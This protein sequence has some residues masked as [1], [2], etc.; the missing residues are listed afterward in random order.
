MSGHAAHCGFLFLYELLTGTKS[1]KVL[2]DDVS[3]SAAALLFEMTSDKEVEGA[4]TSILSLM[5][6]FPRLVPLMPKF[7][8]DRKFK[9]NTIKAVGD[10]SNPTSPLG[11]LLG[12]CLAVIHNEIADI[13]VDVDESVAGPASPPQVCQLSRSPLPREQHGVSMAARVR[14]ESWVIPT[15]SDYSCGS[16]ELAEIPSLRDCDALLLGGS[17]IEAFSTLPLRQIGLDSYLRH[18]TRQQ[19]NCE[20][21]SGELPFDLGRHDHAQSAVARSMLERLRGDA[22]EYAKSQNSGTTPKLH[23]ILALEEHLQRAGA[24]ASRDSCVGHVR[25]CCDRLDQLYNDLVVLRSSDSAY[26]ES[27]V[28]WLLSRANDLSAS[29]PSPAAAKHV[30][31]MV[32]SMDVGTEC[33]RAVATVATASTADAVL[34]MSSLEGS[35]TAD[36]ADEAR[37]RSEVLFALKRLGGREASIWIEFLLASLLSSR[38]L[39]DLLRVN[40]FLSEATVTDLT[41]VMVAFILHASRVGLVNRCINDLVELRRGVHG[42]LSTG[43]DSLA[44]TVAGGS[45]LRSV[46]LCSDS[47]ARNLASGRHFV[48]N[49]PFHFSGGEEKRR[50]TALSYDPRFLV[51]EFTWNL[52]LRRS[53]VTMVR[54]YLGAVRAGESMVKQLIMGQGKTTVVCP[55]LTL[56]LGDGDNLVV[57]VVPPALLDF[58]R[59][60]M[61]S[62]F[63]TIMTKGVFTFSFD[64]SSEVHPSI[65]K[66]LASAK[67][68]RGV[69]ISTPT[70]VKS[71][72]LKYIELLTIVRDPAAMRPPAIEAD[73]AEL[74][75]NF[76]LLRGAVLI[77]DEVKRLHTPTRPSPD[78][79]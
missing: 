70:S 26:L 74:A 42:L 43:Q 46:L 16:R 56:I 76:R 22:L 25:G 68:A 62:T 66:K 44:A 78:L 12:A 5:C 60:I 9:T 67:T 1:L 29:P 20:P 54:D 47:L 33:E 23:C 51:F 4:M 49:V 7:K 39:E 41:N 69:V 18:V 63:S 48:D 75:K 28:P 72:M 52:M 30:A 57:L 37:S 35:A 55:L 34:S 71:L 38:Q 45:A 8:D 50:R 32:D 19:S 36:A 64:R 53:Q 3:A 21:V 14:T 31:H 65:Y 6:R 13:I 24:S 10:E 40:P 59:S 17:E 15:I 11:S 58:S 79:T 77:M 27:A 2:K 73:C 61:R